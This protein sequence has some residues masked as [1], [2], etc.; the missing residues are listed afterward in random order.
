MN[1]QPTSLAFSELGVKLCFVEKSQ[2][3]VDRA[4]LESA[5][6]PMTERVRVPSSPHD[7]GSMNSKAKKVVDFPAQENATA[8]RKFSIRW[9]NK[10]EFF[11]KGYLPVPTLFLEHYAMLNPPLTTG[12]AMFV[13]QVMDHKWD[14]RLPFP[15]YKTIA[16][17]M[18]ISD[19]MARNHACSLE[20]KKYL[21]RRMRV[22]RTNRF[23]FTQL[24]DALSSL[25]AKK[26]KK[27]SVTA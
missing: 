8:E 26:G 9:G 4:A 19:K 27:A 25:L 22:G 14:A 24:F 17:R 12:E 11:A 15:G 6:L 16:K 13:L 7:E 10:P 3:E 18:G 1:K 2:I 5:R 23:D 20:I 21:Y